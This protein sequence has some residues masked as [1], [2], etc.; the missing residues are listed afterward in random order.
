LITVFYFI[1]GGTLIMNTKN[2]RPLPMVPGLLIVFLSATGSAHAG[3]CWVELFDKPAFAGA[4]IRLDGP[5]EWPSLQQLGGSNWS[6]RIESLQVG[7][8]AE[9][10][11]F[12]SENFIETHKGPVAHP[13]ALKGASESEIAASHDLE[14]SF[15]PG[16]QEHHLGEMKFHKNINSLK[17]RCR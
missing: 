14:I 13:D 16:K 4:H 9:V 17:I 10:V 6:N 3:D 5:A 2:N 1:P 7:P 11:A 15:G 12:K 8:K